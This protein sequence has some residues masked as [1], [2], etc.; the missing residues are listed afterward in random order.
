V[1][2]GETVAIGVGDTIVVEAGEIVAVG[3]GDASGDSGMG[4]WAVA[5]MASTNDAMQVSN[6]IFI[7]F[8]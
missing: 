7:M 5:P 2:R 1:A 3:D 8:L 6:R 4:V